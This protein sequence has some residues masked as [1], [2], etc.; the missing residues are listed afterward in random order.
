ME[1]WKAIAKLNCDFDRRNSFDEIRC[2]LPYSQPFAVLRLSGPTSPRH[3]PPSLAARCV[4]I[5]QLFLA[6]FRIVLRLR[7]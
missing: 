1:E 5:Q 4:R 7:N 2:P 3:M 6:G